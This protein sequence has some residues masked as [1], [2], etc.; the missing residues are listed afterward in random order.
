[1]PGTFIVFE[2]GEGSGKTTHAKLCA[3]YLRAQGKKVTLTLEPGGTQFGTAIRG[4]ILS[5][6]EYDLTPRAELLCFLA[7]RAQHVAEVIK[8][9]LENDEVVICDRFSGST[10]AYQ[11]GGRN[12]PQPELVK[13]MEAY[14]R[15]DLVPDAVVYLDINPED[16]IMRKKQGGQELDR[17]DSESLKFHE[18]V[19]EYFLKLAQDEKWIVIPTQDGTQQENQQRIRAAMS[20]LFDK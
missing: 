4:L 1:M 2:G 9:R 17:L 11:L 15:M 7:A 5:K 18:R 10:F 20:S 14:A 6:A 16:G 8:P 13:A 3:E 19:H 12:L